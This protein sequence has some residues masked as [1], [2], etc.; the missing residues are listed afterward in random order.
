LKELLGIRLLPL[1]SSVFLDGVRSL[2]HPRIIADRAA[3]QPDDFASGGAV[4]NQHSNRL[5][6]QMR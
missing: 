4:L 3:D 5:F 1:L 6:E 2:F